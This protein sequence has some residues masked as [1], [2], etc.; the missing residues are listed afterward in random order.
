MKNIFA[1]LF[2]GLFSV[3]LMLSG[4]SN[5]EKVLGFLDVAGQWDPSLAFV[6]MGAIVV[7]FIPFQLAVRRNQPKT[8]F[9]DAIDLPQATQ[10]DAKLLIGASIFGIGWGLTGV[11]PAPAFTLIG[12]GYT[13]ILYFIVAMFIGVLAHKKLIGQ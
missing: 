12:L 2:G 13:Q 1:F 5:P 9:G 8:V 7:A 10:I 3:G 11:C 6:M 4:M